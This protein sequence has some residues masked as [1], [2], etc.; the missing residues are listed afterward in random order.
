M[1]YLVIAAHPDDE[2]LGCGGSMAKWIKEGH[3]VHIL[4]MAEGITSREKLRDKEKNRKE[5]STL[6]Q[7]AV[8]SANVLGVN[9]INFL[10]YPDNRMDSVDLLDIIKSIEDYISK[11]K[12][13]TLVTHHI[14]DLNIDH[15]I[16]HRAV[17][18]ASRPQPNFC[19][20]KVISYEVPSSTEW[21]SSTI[22]AFQPNYFEDISNTL[23][24][25]IE[26][27]KIYDSEMREWPHARSIEA[28]KHLAAWR[29]SSI[30]C[31]AAEAFVLHREIN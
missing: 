23:R 27:L 15:Q 11:F 21:Q 22:K 6:S 16:I 5:I 12:P 31:E 14:N 19:V 3:E 2:V 4:I 8:N 24:N 25:K 1:K 13:D 18:T 17:L 7:S 20:K 28:I 10:N 29:G 30:G 9:S 26:A